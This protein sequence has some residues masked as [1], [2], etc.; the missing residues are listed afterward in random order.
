MKENYIKFDKRINE[1]IYE[2]KIQLKN[3]N[4]KDFALLSKKY[5]VPFLP[6]TFTE[7]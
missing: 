1:G 3:V 4:Q 5:A 6:P 2:A 7:E